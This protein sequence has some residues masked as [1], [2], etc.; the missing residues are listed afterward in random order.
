MMFWL[1][2]TFFYLFVCII[3]FLYLHFLHDGYVFYITLLFEVL[4]AFMG[5]K[6]FVCVIFLHAII[7]HIF[8][9]IFYDQ[10]SL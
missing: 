10:Y 6:L 8:F 1:Y 7:S 5:I 9:I 3:F 4:H 2:I